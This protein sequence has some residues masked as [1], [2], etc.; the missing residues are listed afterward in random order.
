[1]RSP[2]CLCV[3]SPSN[4][5][6]ACAFVA[7][8]TRLPR[9]CLGTV[10]SSGSTIPAFRRHVTLHSEV[11]GRS[12]FYAAGVV[13]NTQYAVKVKKVISPPQNLL[14]S[15]TSTAEYKFRVSDHFVLSISVTPL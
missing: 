11:F 13:S 5:F 12:V 7:A 10:V 1:M 8:G 3:C 4:N 9:R 2:C 14:L 15:V 6:Q